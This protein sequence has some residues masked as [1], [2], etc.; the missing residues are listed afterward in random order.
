MTAMSK[1]FQAVAQLMHDETVTHTFVKDVA[2]P[3][4]KTLA[5]LTLDNGLDHKKPTT[6]GPNGLL[7][8]R[9]ALE[10]QAERAKNGEIDALAITGKPYFLIAGADLSAV[11]R[12]SA[13][14]QA[15]AMASLGHYTYELLADLGVPTFAFINGLALGGGLEIALAC[16]YRTVSTAAGA[17][18]LPEGFLG[19]IPGWAGVYRLPRLVGPE[20]ALKVMIENPLNS[21]RTLS[22]P[23]AAKMGV[24]DALFEPADFIEHSIAFAD[25][26]ISGTTEV[27][28]PNAVDPTDPEVARRWLDAADA[29]EKFVDAKLSGAAPAPYKVLE[30]FRKGLAVSQ[31]ESAV[32]E[33][34][35]LTGLMS[36]PQFQN[37][38]YAFLDLVQKRG[39]RPA[40]APDPKLARPVTKVGV[41]GAGLMAGQLA[42]LFARRLNVPVVIT[43]LD[44]SRV[45]KGLAYIHGEIDKLHAKGRMSQDAVNRTKALVTGSVTKK[46]FADADFV[47]EAVF[48]ELNVKKQVFAEVEAVVSPE[49]ILATNTSSLSVTEM[50]RDLSYP[51]RL[52]GFHFFNP[53]AVMPLLEIAA[54]EWTNDSSLSTAF[55]LGKKLKKTTVK[56]K[57]SA[58]FVVN[59]VLLR[60]MSEVQAAFDE[61]TDAKTADSALT[62]MGLPMSPLTLLAMVGLPVAQHV[63]ES[64]NAAFGERFALSENLQKLID[65]KITALWVKDEAGNQVLNPEAEK[66]MAFGDQHSSKE[67]ILARV[68]DALAEEIGL[69]LDEGVVAEAADV[70][71]CM[72]TGAGWPMH[73]GGITPYLDQVGASERVNGKRFNG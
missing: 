42:L 26:V 53:V 8:L 69:L 48:E 17:L 27:K 49:C 64:L 57:D 66:L 35:A 19:L 40:G 51:E 28:R 10:V 37:T 7:E 56:T 23:A 58:A 22:G 11:T 14:D 50:G 33:V 61:G 38:V 29:A 63:N 71:L 24:A 21:N 16:N 41:V 45:D 72:I 13:P 70:D 20:N 1:D 34:E 5:L 73:L 2:L 25:G 44:Q 15:T 46:A 59:R 54:T 62:P 32:L 52:V 55:V 6:L 18:G 9:A 36:T 31:Q 43:D 30:V 47:I 68:Q 4:G 3:S 39:K 12:L 67:Q 60:L 65:A